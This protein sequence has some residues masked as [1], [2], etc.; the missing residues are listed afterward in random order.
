VLRKVLILPVLVTSHPVIP[1]D[2]PLTTMSYS[3][4]VEHLYLLC[5]NVSIV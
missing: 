2:L 3:H 4:V 5:W 1:M